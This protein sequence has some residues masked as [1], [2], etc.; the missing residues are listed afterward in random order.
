MYMEDNHNFD[1]SHILQA[2]LLINQQH[3]QGA[4][5]QDEPLM[6]GEDGDHIDN[7]GQQHILS[8]R[9]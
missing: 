6:L 3:N 7:Y 4:G 1:G 9:E 5:D 2:Q 8:P